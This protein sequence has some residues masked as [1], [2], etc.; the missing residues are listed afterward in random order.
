MRRKPKTTGP[1]A[2]NNPE[3]FKQVLTRMGVAGWRPLRMLAVERDTTITP[4]RS[5]PSMICSRNTGSGSRWKIRCWTINAH[6]V[7]RPNG[8]HGYLVTDALPRPSFPD[9]PPR[10]LEAA[11]DTQLW[12]TY[13]AASARG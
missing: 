10:K 1:T 9:A 13:S 5:R 7:H 3:A 11:P 12:R 4:W 2:R 6:I 8:I